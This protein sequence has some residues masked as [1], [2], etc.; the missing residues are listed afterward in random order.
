MFFSNP[1][2]HFPG[3]WLISRC[4]WAPVWDQELPLHSH[5]VLSILGGSDIHRALKV[6]VATPPLFWF[7]YP[8]IWFLIVPPP[9]SLWGTFFFFQIITPQKQI[10]R[11]A[12]EGVS[13]L[14]FFGVGRSIL[15]VGD[16]VPW[17]GVSDVLLPGGQPPA[18]RAS[19]G[20]HK[21]DVLDFFI[22]GG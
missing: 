8:F 7:H 5:M 15:N 9:V 19:K 4:M 3:S 17:A 2:P 12:C 20:I 21:V 14:G 22:W 11:I 13:R 1:I 18:A 16:T 10:F 6:A